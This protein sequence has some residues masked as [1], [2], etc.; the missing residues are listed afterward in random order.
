[1]NPGNGCRQV[2][3][4]LFVLVFANWGLYGAMTSLQG[5]DIVSRGEW[6]Q[7]TI[8][9]NRAVLYTSGQ[10]TDPDRVYIDFERVSS[11]LAPKAVP[12]TDPLVRGIRIGHPRPGDTRLV[13][14]LKHAASFSI[15]ALP[16]PPRLMVTLR[17][18]TPSVG[19]APHVSPVPT[20]ITLLPPPLNVTGGVEMRTLEAAWTFR[21]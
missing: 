1:M 8:H 18:P 4:A 15:T 14:D 21:A 3:C 10:L 20:E 12:R 9:L 7:V 11:L 17:V 2:A 6:T 16:N 5:I 13:V 19:A